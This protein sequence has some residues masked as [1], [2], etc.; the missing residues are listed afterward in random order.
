MASDVDPGA[1]LRVPGLPWLLDSVD[2]GVIAQD[3]SGRIRLLN[4]AAR[5]LFPD[6]HLGDEFEPSGESFVAESCGR[7]I[8]GRCQE[9]P[10]GWHAWVVADISGDSKEDISGNV[11]TAAEPADQQDFMLEASRELRAGVSHDAAAAALVRLAVPVVAE[12]AA[13]LLPAPRA[14][15]YWWRFVDGAA[16]PTHGMARAPAP[17]TAPVLA[18]ALRGATDATITVPTDEL[19][20][21]AAV[22]GP[23]VAERTP[24]VVA[25]LPGPDRTE[26]LLVVV[27]PNAPK[28]LAQLAVLAGPTIEASRRRRDEATAL[29]LLQA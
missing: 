9:L 5:R 12:E 14:R 19:A 11:D 4:E 28:L 21:L 22:L 6:L 3:P 25:P 13:V 20:T 27:R 10:D 2:Q 15:V 18:S 24:I 23:D 17:R 29:A 7:R 16:E 26:G 1:A 8:S